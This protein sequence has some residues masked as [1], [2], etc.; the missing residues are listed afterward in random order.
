MEDVRLDNE[1]YH[2]WGVVFEV[3]LGGVDDKKNI[4]HA[5]RWYVYMNKKNI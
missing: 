3:N 4:I 2:H 1:R 5:E